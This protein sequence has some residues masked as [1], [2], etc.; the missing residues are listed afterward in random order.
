MPCM[1]SLRA[2]LSFRSGR[3]AS[4]LFRARSWLLNAFMSQSAPKETRSALR[5]T[6]SAL[7]ETRTSVSTC[8]FAHARCG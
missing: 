3:L 6:Q 8:S 1:F 7:D 5:E 4:N 2:F